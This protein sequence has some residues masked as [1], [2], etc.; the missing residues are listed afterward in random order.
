[1]Q[2]DSVD[3]FYPLAPAQQGILFHAQ[4]DAAPTYVSQLAFTFDAGFDER[5]F[6]SAWRRLIERHAIL[7]SFFVWEGLA[8][9]VQV[10]RRRVG[11]PVERHDWRHVADVTGEFARFMRADQQRGFD[12]RKAPAMRLILIRLAEDRYRFLWSHHHILIDGWSVPLLLREFF[13][14]YDA[15]AATPVQLPAQRPFRDY[16]AWLSRQNRAVAKE[17]WD[18][19]LQG[20]CSPTSMGDHELYE[21]GAGAGGDGPACR[22]EFRM[23]RDDSQR[24]L[25][26]AREH[27]LTVNTV[28]LGAWAILLG[29]YTGNDD[30]VFGTTVSG[31]PAELEGVEQMVG[32]FINTLPVRAR[33]HDADGVVG[34]LQRIQ[35]QQ[36]QTRQFEYSRLVD[37]QQ[38]SDVRGGS[39]LFDTVVVIEN[40]PANALVESLPQA[41]KLSDWEF[42]ART[43]YALALIGAIVGDV[44]TL[45]VAHDPERVKASTAN[46]VLA[47]LA[48]IIHHM[49]ASDGVAVGAIE[50]TGE[51]ERKQ[52]VSVWNDAAAGGRSP[53]ETI[54]EAFAAQLRATP[55][56]VALVGPEEALTYLELDRRSNQ[57]ARIL[58]KQGVGPEQIVALYFDRG[59]AVIVAMLAVLKAGAAYLPLDVAHPQARVER[60]VKDSG[61]ALMLTTSSQSGKLQP[62]CPVLEVDAVG[63]ESGDAIDV[64]LSGNNLAYVIYTSGSTGLPKGVMVEHRSVINLV[65]G[66]VEAFGI[67]ARSRTLQFASLSFD[68][69][70]S[71]IFCAL[72]SGSALHVA[73]SAALRDADELTRLLRNREISVVTL[74]PALLAVMT[75]AGFPQLETVVSAGDACDSKIVAKWSAGRRFLNAYGPTETTVCATISAPLTEST[76]VDIGTPLKNARI[77]VL[78]AGLRPVPLGAV[79]EMYVGGVV[80]SR[81]YAHDTAQTAE[82][83]LPD[84]FS[85]VPGSRMYR[86]GD[87]T[88]QL[89]NGCLE[90]LGRIDHQ[91]KLRGFRIELGEIQ[92]LLEQQPTVSQ[93]CVVAAEIVPGHMQLVAY[94]VPRGAAEVQPRE[95]LAELRSKLPEYAVPSAVVVL[96][97]LPLTGSG[98][99]DRAALPAP[100]HAVEARE[101]ITVPRNDAEVRIAAIWRQVLGLDS[102]DINDNFFELG[103]HSLLLMQVHGELKG[104]F[105]KSISITQMF[106][107]PTIAMLAEYFSAAEPVQTNDFAKIHARASRSRAAFNLFETQ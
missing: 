95:L 65:A 82:R 97:A 28:L 106:A 41:S 47:D 22:H 84:P 56:A 39:P 35:Q 2:L 63:G 90:H 94:V 9:P 88:R 1:M 48:R 27:H 44:V 12:L 20:F 83:F 70:V 14:L 16:I 30:V 31:R 29:R 71:E 102:V 91:I 105:E 61:A 57:L 11:L 38:S 18:R 42:H 15:D 98:K 6:E 100:A 101:A 55:H 87:R 17:H 81:G 37:V 66:Q 45:Q 93:A 107:L 5:K 54:P 25:R 50:V 80:L 96:N 13:T 7:R 75:D 49:I 3:D 103:G 64:E 78:D 69:S 76:S 58:R 89:P 73:S 34:L 43:N 99:I 79:G 104:A 21:I 60:I 8:E 85:S 77:Y 67:S 4:A 10:V 68:A 86:T 59:T 33:L 53:A 32:M 40:Y 92:S 74:P 19:V 26:Y 72:L 62:A 51:D 23:P 36:A 52:L 46:R 24:L